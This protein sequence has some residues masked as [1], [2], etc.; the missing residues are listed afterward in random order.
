VLGVRKRPPTPHNWARERGG[1]GETRVTNDEWKMKRRERR[2]GDI[3]R[4]G[5]GR[6]ALAI[7]DHCAID[8][9]Q[10]CDT[11]GPVFPSFCP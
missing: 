11:L 8:D 2:L 1:N 4:R 10:A 9:H 5:L 7:D 6:V 3:G